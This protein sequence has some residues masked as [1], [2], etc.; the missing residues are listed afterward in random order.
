MEHNEKKG[1]SGRKS[2]V[3]ILNVHG[4]NFDEIATTEK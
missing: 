1:K 2:T 4:L 3:E